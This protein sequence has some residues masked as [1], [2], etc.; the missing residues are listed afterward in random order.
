MTDYIIYGFFGLTSIALV[1]ML[2]GYFT[3][4]NL[5]PIARKLRFRKFCAI[6]IAIL[7]F[8]LPIFEP[9]VSSYSNAEFN[10]ELKPMNLNS[11]EELA[12]FE[13]DQTEYIHSLKKDIVE[14]KTDLYKVSRF[15]SA[16]T[17]F[18]SSIL[19]ILFISFALKKKDEDSFEEIEQNNILRL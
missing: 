1:F 3:S 5:P 12:K 2:I 19:G 13:N 15:Y 17:R 8:G 9:F 14:L 16:L 6:G 7:F 4:R 10:E 18:L 11:I